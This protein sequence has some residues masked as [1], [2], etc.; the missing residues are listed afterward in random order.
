[1]THDMKKSARKNEPIRTGKRI[2]FQVS[3]IE[4]EAIRARAEAEF[5]TVA[6]KGRLS[7][8]IRKALQLYVAEKLAQPPNKAL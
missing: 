1:M 2:T 7:A 6:P 3:D 8:L 4:D 5:S